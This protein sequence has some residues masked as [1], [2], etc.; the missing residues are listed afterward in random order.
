MKREFYSNLAILVFVSAL[1]FLNFGATYAQKAETFDILTFKTPKGWQKEVQ[2]NGVQMA[3]ENADGGI[4]LITLFKSVPSGGG[5]SKANFDTAWEAIVKETVTVKTAV[6]M[7]DPADENGWTVESGL[8]QYESD[9]K[10][11]IVMLL[12]ATGNG[13]MVNVLALTNTDAYQKDITDFLESISLPKITPQQTAKQTPKQT[14]IE[15]T[16]PSQ[17]ARKSNFK[18][19]TSNFDDGWISTE[20]DDWVE[21]VKGNIKVLIH[22][23]IPNE[24]KIFP[25]D[26]EPKINAAWDHLVAPRYS[27]LKNYK[28]SYVG[29][30]DRS[31]LGMGYLTENAT[32]KKVF[33]LLFN[34]NAGW[35]EFIAPDK[36]SF[37]RQF[38][39]DPETIQWNSNKDLLKPVSEMVNYNKFAV[40]EGDFTGTWT[41][42]SSSMEEGYGVI[43]GNY[44]VRNLNT[45]SREFVFGKGNSYNWNF[46]WVNDTKVVN[47]NSV[48]KFSV[49]N[50][51][52]IHFSKIESGP[53]TYQA[54]WSCIKGARLL[55]LLNAVSPGSGRYEVYGKKK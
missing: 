12:T 14:P 55:H 38:N 46:V 33:V 47:V 17:P 30:Y 29:D 49:P 5:D 11:G 34:Q 15:P 27:N 2:Q 48:G 39:F 51:W 44:V 9:G 3:V 21:V 1:V 35:L 19:T 45:A 41:S 32:G 20:Q 31:V 4:C 54:Y 7:N 50:N 8:A 22:Y 24:G 40:A 52:Q 43:T 13:K 42:D 28:T 53:K 37:I 25:A 6:Q 10:K 36:D 26:P 16:V 23:P 18:F